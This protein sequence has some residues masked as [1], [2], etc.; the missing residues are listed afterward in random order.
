MDPDFLTPGHI[1]K[2]K[3]FSFAMHKGILRLSLLGFLNTS[4]M[5]TQSPFRD[6]TAPPALLRSNSG[7]LTR[8][9]P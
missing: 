7:P 1:G 3:T 4:L 8:C 5:L 2:L 9:G 6:M